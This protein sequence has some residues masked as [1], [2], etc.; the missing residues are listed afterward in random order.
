MTAFFVPGVEPDQAEA[1][2]VDLAEMVDAVVGHPA[3]RV[4]SVVFVRGAE[5]WTA[6]VG[7]RLS[8]EL[9]AGTGR[10]RARRTSSL[11]SA[12]TRQVSDT[13]TVQAIFDL[14]DSH[15]VVTDALPVGEIHDSTWDNPFS[16]SRH[17]TRRVHR[18]EA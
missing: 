8:G 9:A 6:T 14:G 4:L 18:F 2:Y 12:P 15:L 10:L 7:Q 11:R 17:D 1:R 16:I 13:A 3:S 5:E